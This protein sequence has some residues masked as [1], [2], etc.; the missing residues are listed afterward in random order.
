[1]PCCSQPLF[2]GRDQ[3][4]GRFAVERL[5]HAPLA[6]ALAHMLLDEIVDLRADAA[7]DLAAAL[8][9]PQLGPGMLEPRVLARSDQ[10][11]DLVLERRHPGGIVPVDLPGEIDEGLLVLLGIGPG[12]S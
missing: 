6:G 3:R 5:E 8:G 1:M 2:G 4:R 11:V 9:Q 12:G 10:A 7:D